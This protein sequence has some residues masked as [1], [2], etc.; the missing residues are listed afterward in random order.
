MDRRTVW[1]VLKFYSIV[2][3]VLSPWL[4]L[5]GW[6]IIDSE[7]L[8]IRLYGMGALLCAFLGFGYGEFSVR[9]LQKWY[10]PTT[11]TKVLLY[12]GTFHVMLSFIF[13]L[14]GSGIFTVFILVA[15]FT[16]RD[17]PYHALF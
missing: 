10:E 5:I 15:I 14:L 7:N 9:H 6:A 12:R 16:Y 11:N 13:V 4:V 3:L 8:Y 2:C 17:G 1:K